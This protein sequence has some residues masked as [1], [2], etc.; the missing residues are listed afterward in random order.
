MAR[1]SQKAWNNVI[2]FAMLA[3]I[4][5][6]NIGNFQS[7]DADQP[8]P[9]IEEGAVLL[10]LHIDQDIIERAGKAWRLKMGSP[11]LSESAP[12]PDQLAALIDNWTKALVKRQKMVKKDAFSTPDHVIVLWLAGERNG[13]V[14]STI[15]REQQTYI[16][17]NDEVLLLDFPTIQQL[18]QW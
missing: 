9:I 11:S 10:S 6:L 7:D 2:I 18:T 5:A 15:E 8:F 1:L 3:M 14:I 12:A 17:F 4:F 13:R 16:L